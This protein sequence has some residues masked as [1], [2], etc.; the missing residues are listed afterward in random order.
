M[1]KSKQYSPHA[2]TNAGKM[3]E[4]RLKSQ[5]SSTHAV[6]YAVRM[7]ENTLVALVMQKLSSELLVYRLESDPDH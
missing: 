3:A 4:K 7:V 6:T 2:V 5:Q 1:E